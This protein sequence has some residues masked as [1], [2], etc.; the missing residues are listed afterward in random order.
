MQGMYWLA[1]DLLASQEWLLRGVSVLLT[2]YSI[3]SHIFAVII[4]IC[5]FHSASGSLSVLFRGLMNMNSSAGSFVTMQEYSRDN[6]GWEIQWWDGLGTKYVWEISHVVGIKLNR[7][8][9]GEY[10]SYDRGVQEVKDYR[11]FK[12][13]VN[14]GRWTGLEIETLMT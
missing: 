13:D 6:T 14:Y 2:L 4:K 10:A 7:N 3:I 5:W 9:W 11:T 12:R 1:E 8:T